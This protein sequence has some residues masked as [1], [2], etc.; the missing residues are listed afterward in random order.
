MPMPYIAPLLPLSAFRRTY[1][2]L[3]PAVIEVPT[4]FAQSLASRYH[5]NIPAASARQEA[6][7]DPGLTEE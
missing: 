3:L 1:A 4:T 6:K 5:G 2:K 7:S